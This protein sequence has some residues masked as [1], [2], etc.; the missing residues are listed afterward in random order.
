MEQDDNDVYGEI[1]QII[2]KYP[3][4][5][6][7]KLIEKI[8]NK[9]ICAHTTAIKRLKTLIAETKIRKRKIG[10]TYQYS[11]HAN[12]LE[13]NELNSYLVKFFKDYKDQLEQLKK[14]S[15]KYDV[16]V[17]REMV[18]SF[19]GWL[20]QLQTAGDYFKNMATLMAN[21]ITDAEKN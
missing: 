15:E 8:N 19:S 3:E 17:V 12:Y 7:N 11:L 18:D 1:V 9:G 20:E 16:N 14:D 21:G 5:T 10:N 6:Q 4:I 2:T 13:R